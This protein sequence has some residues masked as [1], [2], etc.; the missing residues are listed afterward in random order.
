MATILKTNNARQCDYVVLQGYQKKFKTMKKKYFVLYSDS[1]T[2]AARLEYYD[3]EKKYKSRSNPKRTIILKNCF[4]INRRLD[5]KHKF[6]IALSIK[7][8]GFS[9]VLD[10]EEE[11]H[12]WLSALLCL[13]RGEDTESESPK[14]IFEHVWQVQVQRKGL[15]EE[16]GLIGSYHVCLTSKSL[17]LVRIGPRT[18]LGENRLYSVEFYLTTIRRCGDSQCYFFMEVGRH[19]AIGAGELWMETEDTLIAQN[20]HTMIINA[21]TSRNREDTFGPMRKRSSSANEASKPISFVQRRQTHSGNKQIQS[22]PLNN[23]II[24]RERCDSLPSR[25]R[26]NSEC[27]NPSITSRAMLPPRSVPSLAN[28]PHSMYNNRQSHSPPI[29][30]ISPS[31][32]C[33]ESEGS[34]LSID[35]TDSFGHSL[36]PD[37]SGNFVS[38]YYNSRSSRGVIPEENPAEFWYPDN[39]K[40]LVTVTETSILDKL[41]NHGILSLPISTNQHNGISFRKENAALH[42]HAESAELQPQ[43]MDMCSPY[44]PCGSSPC[45]PT[46][47]G[48]I[49]ISPSVEGSRGTYVGSSGGHSRASSLA[50]ETTDGYMSMCPVQQHHPQSNDYVDMEQSGKQ[51]VTNTGFITTASSCNITSSTNMKFAEYPLEKV[52]SRFAPEDEDM[53]LINERPTRAY[54]VG[55]RL[56]H[57]KRKLRIELFANNESSNSRVRAFS[58]GSRAKVPRC[59][60]ARGLFASNLVFNNTNS[61]NNNIEVANNSKGTKSSSAPILV[62]KNQ[63]SIERMSDLMEIDFSKN[64]EKVTE[65][66]REHISMSPKKRITS[67]PVSVPTSNLYKKTERVEFSKSAHGYIE[68]RPGSFPE[69]MS[70]PLQK[71]VKDNYGYM[72]MKPTQLT[73]SPPNISVSP[74]KLTDTMSP[75]CVTRPNKTANKVISRELTDYINLSPSSDKTSS[76]TSDEQILPTRKLGIEVDNIHRISNT[77]EGY[78]EMS[79]SKP[80]EHPYK[81]NETEDKQNNLVNRSIS[82]PI[83]IKFKEDQ[84]GIRSVD[85]KNPVISIGN[86]G[87]SNFQNTM[88]SFSPNS[89]PK[90]VS[91]FLHERKCLVDATGGTVTIPSKCNS[92]GKLEAL[93]NEYADM[94]LDTGAKKKIKS[95][96]T[97]NSLENI[98]EN[99]EYVNF[100]PI[101]K[102][103]VMGKIFNKNILEEETQNLQQLTNTSPSFITKKFPIK[104]KSHIT[105]FEG[106]KPI[107]SGNDE[108]FYKNNTKATPAKSNSFKQHH[109]YEILQMRGESSLQSKRPLS[110]PN[111]VNSDK[112]SPLKG[113]V[114]PNSAN[115]E[116]I[117][118]ISTSSSTSTLCGGGSSSSSS[119]LCGSKSQSPLTQSR[120]QSFTDTS[121]FESIKKKELIVSTTDSNL[122]CITSRPPSVISDKEL[123]Y[124]SLDLPQTA[125]S[126]DAGVI[127]P[128]ASC[129]TSVT[130]ANSSTSG[131]S[132][133]SPS[134][135]ASCCIQQPSFTYA[136]IDFNKSEMLKLTTLN[137]STN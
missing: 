20:M 59:D 57:N 137:T 17:Q 33:S 88:F 25:N 104:T 121:S 35:E 22:S 114:R 41:N 28:R 68:M 107:I 75:K 23:V 45:D 6:V 83:D 64:S 135:N 86:D 50:E 82:M 69:S 63:S 37:E 132:S 108:L 90:K 98:G 128:L 11:L 136:Q 24:G 5:T 129:L 2:N 117:L 12:K 38:R 93:T 113:Q 103:T 60:L 109:G 51:S 54:S 46:G 102:E 73:K 134:P 94:T 126:N 53:Q 79:W 34:S 58:V 95:S 13:Q 118:S 39:D 111:S 61:N 43:Y 77:P 89:P 76:I 120:P 106:F 48:Y 66:Q 110:R 91:E 29:N 123:H 96:G 27:S 133:T 99:A 116:S 67:F 55:S 52:I 26:T 21:M 127:V 36:T 81:N 10:S 3:S 62:H 4:N 112:I 72:E 8:G 9:I 92:F 115:S 42:P 119:T 40:H 74:H 125:N 47:S 1:P 56:E 130:K 80:R 15:A 32:G 85:S 105:N 30:A 71:S 84:D 19:S 7:D 44:S 70:S 65:P 122:S 31:I 14:P 16:K 131:E 78:I 18:N 100:L 101:A 87:T 97:R 49:P 124:A